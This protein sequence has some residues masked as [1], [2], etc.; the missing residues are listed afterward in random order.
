MVTGSISRAHPDLPGA[1]P[2]GPADVL[3]TD[4]SVGV[5]RPLRLTDR[6]A[7]FALHD[8]VGLESLRLRFFSPSRAAGHAYVDHLLAQHDSGQVLALGLW[9][10]HRLGG[11]ATAER[12][13]DES[14]VPFLVADE[15]R[16][17][18]VGTLLLEHLAASARTAG[19]RRF[20]AE[21][22]AE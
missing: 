7:L 16:G 8:E 15:L 3:L 9:Q 1:P 13:G 18:G 17:H 5:I 21:V 12:V 6:D 22:L 14:E 2:T 19:V 4:G 11:L 20:T 10:H